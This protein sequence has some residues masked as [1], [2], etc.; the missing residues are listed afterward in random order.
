MQYL[1]F[2]YGDKLKEVSA[3]ANPKIPFLASR[4]AAEGSGEEPRKKW[5][6]NFRG[7]SRRSIAA[8]GERRVREARV[9][10]GAVGNEFG[11]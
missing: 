4:L 1:N 5:Q 7:A 2:A 10:P 8:A 3:G 9:S 11:F 6:G